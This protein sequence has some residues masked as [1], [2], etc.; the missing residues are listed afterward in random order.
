MSITQNEF[1]VLSTF[2][3]TGESL[4]PEDVVRTAHLPASI[5]RA[6]MHACERKGFVEDG[7]LTELGAKELEPYR[8]DNAIIMAAGLS[9][10]FVPISY[11]RP[12]GV[13][14]VKGEV[15]IERQ[16]EQLLARGITDITVVV[17][18]RKEYFFYLGAKYGVKI[19]VNDKYSERNN[20]WTLWLVRQRLANTFICSSD[21]YFEQNPF[22]RY[23]WHAYYAAQY[24]RGPTDEWC[25]ETDDALR[26]TKVTTSGN[27]AWAMLGH[28]YFDRNFSQKYSQILEHEAPLPENAD[29]LWESLLINH[30]D[31]LDMEMRCYPDG[32]IHEFDTLEEVEDYDPFFL[33]NVDS[34]VFD[35]I[36]SVLGCK[37]EDISGFHRL[38]QGLTNLSCTFSVGD[39]TY[40]YRY[41]GIGT[42]KLVD[43]YAEAQANAAGRKLGLDNTYVFEDPAKGWKIS[44]FIENAR[45]L[46]PSKND[47]LKRAMELCRTMH[48]SGTTVDREFDYFESG[49]DYERAL[50]EHGPIRIPGYD[51]LRNKVTKLREYSEK[52][53][54]PKA[55][56][57]NDFF[58]LNIL[59]A[60]DD[61]ISLIDWEYAGMADPFADLATFSVC[62]QL[63][64]DRIELALSYYLGRTP[65]KAELR[66][67]WATIV[68]CGWCW[69]VWSL[70][71]ESDGEN[72][73]EWLYIYYQ[74]AADNVDRV[75]AS[76]EEA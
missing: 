66:H 76:Y 49:V 1:E 13:L 12:K 50:L 37:R 19:V 42:E 7:R 33:E 68:Q 5:C 39:Q 24:Q 44:H 27:D 65:T 60:Q 53:G 62:C 34:S 57:H 18:Y 70:V 17:G 46:D 28:A 4:T 59:I 14:R 2:A 26:I 30:L 38:N 74:Y 20:A 32:M 71:K 45:Y 16:I 15:L 52:D 9:S 75:L 51:G 11:E 67:L 31:V 8:V 47:D 35:N 6:T 72:V 22:E 23:V 56:S 61:S 40:V 21:D 3:A 25:M 10:R 64:K 48:E 63:E 54:Y 55:F 58:Y 73:G 29:K 43:R 41:P 36:V 69:Y